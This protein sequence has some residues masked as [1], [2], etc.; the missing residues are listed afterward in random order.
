M[1]SIFPLWDA[2]E[3]SLYYFHDTKLCAKLE[4]A[5]ENCWDH[6][7]KVNEWCL[8]DC[9]HCEFKVSSQIMVRDYC[10]AK[11]KR[12]SAS[13]GLLMTLWVIFFLFKIFTLF[14]TLK[15]EIK[16]LN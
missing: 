5:H 4:K 12:F 8:V 11:C 14:G 16:I 9:L 7:C 1:R 10:I 6:V 15:L 2:K 13:G 3:I